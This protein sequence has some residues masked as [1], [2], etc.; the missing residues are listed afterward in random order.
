MLTSVA[1]HFTALL[2][3]G[4]LWRDEANSV[5][6][7]ALPSLG[8]I[9]EK[10]PFD[11]FPVLWLL[12]LRV[13]SFLGFGSTDLSL[14]L[15]G[16]IVSLGILGALW[17]TGRTLA[18][19]LP[20]I[21][22]ALFAMCP[23]VFACDSLRAWGLGIFLILLALAAMWRVLE[24]PA[25]RR[26]ASCSVIIILSAQCL[27]HNSFL[28][29]AICTGAAATGLYRRDLKLTAFPLAAGTLAALSMLPY[30][31]TILRFRDFTVIQR[32]PV[33]LPWIWYKFHSAIEPSGLI[34]ISVW[35]ILA[36]I[37]VVVFTRRSFRDAQTGADREKEQAVFLL[38]T[39]LT[40]IVSYAAFIR[41]LS[42]P[43]Q[44]WYYLP[45]MAVMAVIIDKGVDLI[46]RN[47][48]AGRTIRML[49]SIGLAVFAFTGLWNTVHVRRTNMDVLAAK[50]GTL[51]DKKDL[52]VVSPFYYGISFERYYDGAAAW[53]TLPEVAD[54]SVH[55]YDLL[56]NKMAEKEPI[57]PVLRKITGTLRAG[58]RVWLVGGLQ[59]PPP[60][61]GSGALPP[62][63]DSPYGW[64]EEAYQTAWS[65][66]AAFTLRS[67][68]RPLKRIPLPGVGRVSE[69][70]NPPLFM[71][72][73]RQHRDG[74]AE[75]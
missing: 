72:G 6:I 3:S 24:N 39:M 45:L 13:W 54:H 30:L 36:F 53:T 62:A 51:A 66:E 28:I 49:F 23:T 25:P 38:A 8:A 63:P 29:L 50:L 48:V 69:F 46:C 70:E 75:N 7:S 42:L 22:I 65:Q 10:L 27:Y 55:R 58:H 5:N 74:P 17:H 56:K 43:T 26:M 21:A 33:S 9:W 35:V 71:V 32:F 20:F 59:P 68:S 57:R 12:V 14:R 73:A 37:A 18:V 67:D 61:G 52:I 64:S 11:S 19:R 31:S 16:F 47:S 15:L 4:G 44:A 60:G 40:A 1:L 2:H 41:I 34:L